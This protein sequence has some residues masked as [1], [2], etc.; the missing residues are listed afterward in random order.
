[1]HKNP[2][3]LNCSLWMWLDKYPC[4]AWNVIH[5]KENNVNAHPVHSGTQIVN[6]TGN[7]TEETRTAATET[8]TGIQTGGKGVDQADREN[9]NHPGIKTETGVTEDRNRSRQ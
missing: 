6:Q 3:K 4:E 1:M 8:K 9:H 7:L 2:K 5:R